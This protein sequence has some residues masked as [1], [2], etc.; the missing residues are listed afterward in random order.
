MLLHG[1]HYADRL[2]IGDPEI[3]QTAPA[4]RLR[5]F[6]EDWYR[7]DLMAVVAVGDFDGDRIESMIR[8]HFGGLQGPANA[9]PRTQTDVPID[10]P[11]LVTIA[12]DPEMPQ[13]QVGVLYKQP[14]SPRGTVADFR[15]ARVRSLYSAMLNQP[16]QGADAPGGS[17]LPLWVRGRG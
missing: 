15:R 7:P 9:R 14:P 4:E 5:S 12:T 11:P 3:L 8:E 6:Y 16:N 10:H 1:S 13:S 2:P 17:A